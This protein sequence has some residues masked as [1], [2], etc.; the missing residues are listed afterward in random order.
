MG[1]LVVEAHH[2]LGAELDR[3]VCSAGVV[4]EFRFEDPRRKD[5]D[6]GSRLPAVVRLT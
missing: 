2:L 6:H 5:P 3:G 1:G 4:A